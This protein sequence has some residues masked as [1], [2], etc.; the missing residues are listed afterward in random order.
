MN[1]G[2]RRAR[3]I[4]QTMKSGK[5]VT[6]SQAAPSG[7]RQ[8]PSAAD[9]RSSDAEG[10]YLGG[11]FMHTIASLVGT[12]MSVITS[13]GKQYQGVFHTVS[14]RFDVALRLVHLVVGGKPGHLERNLVSEEMVFPA[15]GIARIIVENISLEYATKDI[16]AGFAT[17]GTI[18]GRFN[19]ELQSKDLQ[20]WEGPDD[21]D[22][23]L[24]LEDNS[25]GWDAEEMFRKNAQDF[26]VKSTYEDDLSGYTVPLRREDTEEFRERERI[27]A[28]KAAE[29]EG[30]LASRANAELENG[31][32]EDQFAAVHRP[33]KPRIGSPGSGG[34]GKYVPPSRRKNGA[35][36]VG[37]RGG[38][39][40]GSGG[41]GGGG[42]RP[43]PPASAAVAPSVNAGPPQQQQQQPPP[44]QQQMAPPQVVTAAAIVAGTAHAQPTRPGPDNHKLQKDVRQEKIESSGGLPQRVEASQRRAHLAA[45]KQQEQSGRGKKP[46]QSPP[47]RQGPPSQGGGG[48]GGGG[49]GSHHQHHRQ[50]GPNLGGGKSRD[51]AAEL[52]KFGKDFQLSEG[53][54]PQ[55]QQQQLL[56]QQQLQQPPQATVPGEEPR[57]TPG[58]TPKPGMTAGPNAGGGEPEA[59]PSV[60]SAVSTTDVAPIPDKSIGSTLNPNA[61]EFVLNP[62]AKAFTPRSP[63]TT[64]PPRVHTPQ[65]QAMMPPGQQIAMTMPHLTGLS[66]HHGGGP[67]GP[68]GQLPGQLGAHGPLPPSASSFPYY[69]SSPFLPI[70]PSSHAAAVA[71]ASFQPGKQPRFKGVGGGPG[72]GPPNHGPGVRQEIPTQAAVTGQ[73]ILAASSG[74]IPGIQQF[75]NY[76]PSFPY[77][78]Y[79]MPPGAV[80]MVPTFNFDGGAQQFAQGAPQQPGMGPGPNS[81]PRN[82]P[83]PP[84]PPLPPQQ[85]QQ[86]L[87][88]HHQ[89]APGTPSNNGNGGAGNG[90]GGGNGAPPTPTSSAGATTP[91]T[92]L[93]PSPGQIVYYPSYPGPH[94]GGHAG[95]P[96]PQAPPQ[97]PHQHPHPHPLSGMFPSGLPFLSACTTNNWHPASAEAFNPFETIVQAIGN[98]LPKPETP[99]FVP[100]E[101]REQ[102]MASDASAVCSDTMHVCVGCRN[103]GVMCALYFGSQCSRGLQCVGNPV[104]RCVY[105]NLTSELVLPGKDLG[106]DEDTSRIPV[107]PVDNPLSSTTVAIPKSLLEVSG[108]EAS[109]IRSRNTFGP[110]TGQR[111]VP[112]P[113]SPAEDHS[114]SNKAFVDNIPSIQHSS[115]TTTTQSSLILPLIPTSR[116]EAISQ[117]KVSPEALE[118]IRQRAVLSRVLSSLSTIG[119]FLVILGLIYKT[120]A[121]KKKMKTHNS[122]EESDDE[123]TLYEVELGMHPASDF[124]RVPGR[125]KNNVYQEVGLATCRGSQEFTEISNELP[126]QA[127][128]PHKVQVVSISGRCIALEP[129]KNNQNSLLDSSLGSGQFLMRPLVPIHQQLINK[130]KQNTHIKITVS[131]NSKDIEEGDNLPSSSSASHSAHPI[132]SAPVSTARSNPAHRKLLTDLPDLQGSYEKLRPGYKTHKRPIAKHLNPLKI[133]RY[134]SLSAEEKNQC[135]LSS[136]ND[137]QQRPEYESTLYSPLFPPLWRQLL[138]PEEDSLPLVADIIRTHES[139]V[140]AAKLGAE[141]NVLFGIGF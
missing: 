8:T 71:A 101:T 26:K 1:S 110:R 55:Q 35:D 34:S 32:E 87:M 31:N 99:D 17:D 113:G 122:R 2:T 132:S 74:G 118:L 96:Q 98:L 42:L 135:N 130:N 5:P 30:S 138:A 43:S 141:K 115:T 76:T 107:S 48:S 15:S 68:G 134:R 59:T 103:A 97:H 111:T 11:R 50:P 16:T 94:V 58:S 37:P 67:H 72:G 140:K 10:I 85:Q 136:N 123:D 77:Q 57:N 105:W 25:N 45:E 133:R 119:L 40:G 29:I 33:E 83:G 9:L 91:T 109:T 117:R 47:G 124:Y 73:P 3:Q 69:L 14:P 80:P 56:Q 112:Q 116:D 22:D 36:R 81:T 114:R 108:R 51:T 61:K 128:V 4:R 62:N 106:H 127:N 92:S 66:L 49:M 28:L 44:Q 75:V 46:N 129:V 120:H 86:Q 21:G 38:G 126:I 102:C 20:P 65:Q 125:R 63:S 137:K 88:F 78:F 19:G 131:P 64:T 27:A 82:T 12:E 54:P 6:S 89:G 24:M 90:G 23:S 18:S 41:G 7:A 121:F 100:C 93:G 79:M 39:G 104:Q 84:G 52:K 53:G 13:D 139:A 95:P 60:A 70:V